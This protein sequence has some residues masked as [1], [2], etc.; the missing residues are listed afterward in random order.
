MSRFDTTRA[1]AVQA[2]PAAYNNKLPC[3]WGGVKVMMAF[4]ALPKS[5]RTAFVNRAIKQGSDFLL[6]VD[7]ALARYPAGYGSKPSSNWWKFG[8][9]VFYITD[10]LQN[11]EALVALGF[12][13][14]RRLS[15]AIDVVREKQD[16]DGRWPLEY[17]YA[18]KTWADF[19]PK[20]APNKWV[21]LRAVRMLRSV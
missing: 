3:A 8:F 19:G 4:G 5:M 9:P 18:G 21:T 13:R 1:N 10:L 17:E 14:D 15:N 6:G 7:P 2:L 12:G 11:I 16:A 20:K